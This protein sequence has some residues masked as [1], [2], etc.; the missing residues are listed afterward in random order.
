M[1]KDYRGT[2]EYVLTDVSYEIKEYKYTND[3][4]LY[5]SGQKTYDSRGPGQS[6][7]I[8]IG[9]KLYNSKGEVLHSGTAISPGVCEGESWAK[10]SC[11]KTFYDLP[12]DD[13]KLVILSTN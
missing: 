10:E 11:T 3:I 9:L 7:N 1:S 13:Y 4:K 8:S 5:F 12:K 6:S 2:Q